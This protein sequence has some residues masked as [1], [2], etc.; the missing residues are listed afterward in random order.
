MK[1]FTRD[2]YGDPEVLQLSEVK[3]P[4]LQADQLMVKNHAISFNPAEWHI[5]RGKIWLIRLAQGFFKP[6]QPILGA[7]V[8][9][10]IIAI[11]S[12]VKAFKVGDKV[13]GR[14]HHTALSEISVL[15]ASNSAIVPQGIDF[16]RA[17][18]L[19]LAA[20]TARASLHLIDSLKSKVVLIN[21]ASG[22]IG[23]F[24]VQIAKNSGAQVYAIS[25]HRNAGMVKSLGAKRVYQ[26]DKEDPL[27]SEMCY[28][29]IVDLIGNLEVARTFARLKESGTYVQVGYSSFWQMAQFL[30]YAVFSR[31]KRLTTINAKVSTDS[32][33]EVALAIASEQIEPVIDEEF[34]FANLPNALA[35]LGT[36]R[37][38]GK[39]VVRF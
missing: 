36:K 18:T 14:A 34:D 4:D 16:V 37:A 25:S 10:E 7:D 33:E 20:V 32:L 3:M 31:R 24:A 29:L 22:G 2:Q 19:P 39:I 5:L 13:F 35:Y 38:K 17:S 8:A 28:D 9:G 21:G 27:T 23:T 15:E 6:K 1:A 11:G 12:K 30:F 26:Y